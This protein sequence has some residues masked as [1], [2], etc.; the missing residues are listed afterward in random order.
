MSETTKQTGRFGEPWEVEDEFIGDDH[1]TGNHHIYGQGDERIE[2]E[3]GEV[4]GF[5]VFYSKQQAQRAAACVNAL[6][7]IPDPAKFVEVFGQMREA[8]NKSEREL[9]HVVNVMNRKG[10]MY[11]DALVSVRQALAAAKEVAR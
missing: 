7:G 11:E 4:V 6:D 8:L 9:N 2:E 1:P 5:G 3:A 10:G